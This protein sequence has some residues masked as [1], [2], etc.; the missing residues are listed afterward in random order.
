MNLT[1][2]YNLLTSEINSF[3]ILTLLT[4]LPEN[5]AYLLVL[6]V[7]RICFPVNDPMYCFIFI[8]EFLAS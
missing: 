2:L 5:T 1:G 8:N 6:V 4:N 7:F 3:A